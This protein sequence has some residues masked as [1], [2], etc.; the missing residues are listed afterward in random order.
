MLDLLLRQL[1]YRPSLS[2][3]VQAAW[4]GGIS[5]WRR[6]KAGDE[7][8]LTAL[9]AFVE[10]GTIGSDEELLSALP[11]EEAADPIMLINATLGQF[12]VCEMSPR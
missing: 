1:G 2:D 11:K 6:K 9:R 10:M 3:E 4:L 12:E 8:H 5:G 7:T